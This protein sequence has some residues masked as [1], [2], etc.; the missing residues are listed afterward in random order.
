MTP[1]RVTPKQRWSM[2]LHKVQRCRHKTEIK[3]S[4]EKQGAQAV[5]SVPHPCEPTEQ[6]T[7]CVI[8]DSQQNLR[9]SESKQHASFSDFASLESKCSCKAGSCNSHTGCTP[10]TKAAS[11]T[12]TFHFLMQFKNATKTF[13]NIEIYR[14]KALLQMFEA[15]KKSWLRPKLFFILK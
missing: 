13:T 11:L 2:L 15:W 6:V 1:D 5:C 8:L 12:P 14:S 9:W 7:D 4:L 3:G 10:K